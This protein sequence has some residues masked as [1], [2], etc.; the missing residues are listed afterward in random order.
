MTRHPLTLVALAGLLAVIPPVAMAGDSAPPPPPESLRFT[1]G[2]IPPIPVAAAGHVS[3]VRNGVRFDVYFADGPNTAAVVYAVNTGR[4]QLVL[5]PQHHAAIL[6]DLV[7]RKF[8]VIVADFRDKSLAGV[9]LEKYVVQLTA[10]AREVADG[11]LPPKGPPRPAPGGPKP[12]SK[13]GTYAAD[14]YTLMP[15]FTVERDVAWFRYGDVPA[16]FR[17]E[18][19]RQLDQ[20]FD[21]ADAARTNTYD[22]VYPA[23]GPAVG[24]VTNYASD[25][26]G[27][28]DY[29]PLDARYLVPAFALKNLAVVHQQYFTD[30]V[31]GYPKGYG[32]YGDQFAACFVRHLKGRAARYHLDPDKVCG[33]GHSKGSEVPGMLVNRLRGTPRYQYGKADFKK[34]TLPDANRTVRSAD[35]HRSTAIACAILGAGVANNELGSDK[36]MPWADDP[37]RNIS[38]FFLYADHTPLTRQRTRGVAAKAKAHGVP[39][40]T[41]DLDAHTWPTGDAYDRAS[42]FADRVLRPEY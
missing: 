40:E 20:P 25:E 13:T 4:R 34:I 8:T 12:T 42:V 16:A 41:A 24:V 21:E 31:G 5:T 14:Y 37:A 27:R 9:D 18:I 17:R 1:H 35:A 2:M 30:P 7:R 11:V 38:Q 29:Y 22:V 39:V 19:A 10:D 6:D 3:A 15:G 23:Y 32:F 33:F 36:A 28:E 26:K